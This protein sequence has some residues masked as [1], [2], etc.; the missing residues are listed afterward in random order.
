[1]T[2]RETDKLDPKVRGWESNRLLAP[3]MKAH[4][5]S[6]EC[7]KRRN[8]RHQPTIERKFSDTGWLTFMGQVSYLLNALSI[9]V[10]SRAASESR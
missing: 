6:V 10:Q 9:C 8:Y 3:D 2:C 1:V 5:E 4:R 7:D